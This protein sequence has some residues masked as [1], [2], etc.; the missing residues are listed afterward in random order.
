MLRLLRLAWP[1]LSAPRL[2]IE[3][4]RLRI[5]LALRWRTNAL[6][7][8]IERLE[9]GGGPAR[10]TWSLERIGRVT[11]LLLRDRP[12]IRATCLHRA[13]IRFALLRASG[14]PVSFHL[15]LSD[16]PVEPVEGHAWVELHGH[17]LFEP[18]AT[19]YIQT[20]VYGCAGPTGIQPFMGEGRFFHR[21]VVGSN[22]GSGSVSRRRSK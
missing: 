7:E 5:W 8:L 15:G 10:C 11:T 20:Y 17:A 1:A 12:P 2:T 21:S 9:R 19:R 18:D 4:I 14:H 6:D 3:V 16:A 13:L 22:R